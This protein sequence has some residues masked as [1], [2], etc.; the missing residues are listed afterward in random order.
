MEVDVRYGTG[1]GAMGRIAREQMSAYQGDLIHDG[2][3]IQRHGLDRNYLWAIRSTGTYICCLDDLGT[4]DY[5]LLLF[6]EIT[7]SNERFFLVGKF[8]LDGE[9][10]QEIDASE[11][12]KILIDRTVNLMEEVC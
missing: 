2:T 8:Y 12:Y 9:Y 10:L 3:T 11:A 7:R 1:F 5:N 4:D 6:D